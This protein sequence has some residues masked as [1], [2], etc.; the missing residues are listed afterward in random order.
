MTGYGEATAENGRYQI[1]VRVRG[2]NHRFLDIVVRLGEEQRRNEALL[3]ATVAERLH[4]GRVEVGG[5]IRY[6]GQ[7]RAVVTVQSEVLDELKEVL[8]GLD[9]RGWSLAEVRLGDLLRVPDLLKVEWGEAGWEDGDHRLLVATAEAALD[10]LLAER[11]REGAEIAEVLCHRLAE[12]ESWVGRLEERRGE[13]A[14]GL[15][16]TLRARL[17][18]LAE[19]LEVDDDRLVQEVAV[20]VDRSDVTEELDRLRSHLAGFRS[21]IEGPGPVGKRLDFLAQEILRELNTLGS[22]C[23]DGEM[24]GW[25]V[26]AKLA[27]EQLREQVQNVE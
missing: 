19:D 16:A 17:A 20:L 26:E 12:L 4:R 27:C 3:R 13:V 21:G 14:D 25:V 8:D 23:R 22:K 2:V 24:V 11:E 7:R 18:S 5:E 10:A 6:L 9:E 1:A 15:H